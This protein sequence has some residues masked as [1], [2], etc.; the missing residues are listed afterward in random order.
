MFPKIKKP[1]NLIYLDHAA[2]TP[3]DTVVK[4]AMEPFLGEKFGNPS[5]LYEKGREARAAIDES[6][7]TIARL[8]GARPSEIIFTAGGTESV[9]LAI[10]GVARFANSVGN[11]FKPFPTRKIAPHLIASA[12]EHHCVL[13][14][15]QALAEEGFKTTLAPVD[16]DGFINIDKLKAAVRPETIFISVMLANNEIGTIQPVIEIGKWLRG[17]N[18]QRLANHLSPILFHTD[19]CQAAGSL[20][21]N[22]DRLGV[23]L[24]SVNG[25]K[26]YGPKQTG[27]LYVRSGVYLKPL[28]YGGGQEAG[29][30]S[31]TENVAGIV[32]LAKAFE[33]AQDEKLR[34][35]EIRKL[36]HLQGYLIKEIKKKIKGALLNGPDN[37]KLEVNSQ[38]NNYK[39]SADTVIRRLPNNVNFTF[40]GVEGESLMLYLD[41]YGIAVSTAS[42]CSTGTTD[43]SHVLLAIGRSPDEAKSSIRFSLGKTTTKK[44]WDYLI[45]GVA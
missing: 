38:N 25:S 8:I 35:L 9:N 3:L 30:R 14:S 23:D 2:T 10:F 28:I 34:N 20:D 4:K 26:I 24:M 43:P 16:G 7:M 13:N 32:G 40:K 37:L 29:L 15:F 21:L 22:V 11:G 17:L 36:G 1:K 31:G 27:F 12:I 42:A 45:Y 44:D 5:S 18:H 41:S 33:R 6:R 39:S 19:A